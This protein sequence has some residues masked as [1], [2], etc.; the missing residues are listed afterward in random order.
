[1]HSKHCS[2]VVAL[3]CIKNGLNTLGELDYVETKTAS[4]KGFPK[5][6]A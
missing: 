6:Q 2:R 4:L 1:M 3:F 5:V